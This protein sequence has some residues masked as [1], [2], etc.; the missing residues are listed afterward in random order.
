V[1]STEVGSKHDGCQVASLLG[2]ERASYWKAAGFVNDCV[3]LGRMRIGSVLINCD[4][5]L[6]QIAVL[7]T[8]GWLFETGTLSAPPLYSLNANPNR[9]KLLLGFR[10]A[11]DIFSRGTRAGSRNRQNWSSK[12]TMYSYIFYN[13]VPTLYMP[14][15]L[16]ATFHRQITF[17]AAC[18]VLLPN[19][20]PIPS[21]RFLPLRAT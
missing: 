1:R 18:F 9:I 21:S 5:R 20:D 10:A 19:I 12:P 11:V 2:C 17:P 15:M 4:V 16:Q 13:A 7:A 6:V 8:M 3:F 14:K